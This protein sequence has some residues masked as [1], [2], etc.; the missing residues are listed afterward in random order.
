[1]SCT[2]ATTA[3]GACRGAAEVRGSGLIESAVIGLSSF[4][5]RDRRPGGWEGMV[6]R[7]GQSRLSDSARAVARGNSPLLL[8]VV[9]G[10]AR[11]VGS[12]G[13]LVRRVAALRRNARIVAPVGLPAG[14]DV[15]Q[16]TS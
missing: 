6:T 16:L 13:R 12:A 11:R 7:A 15:G 8:L 5:G 10:R 4:M 2:I 1:M 9:L 3:A 14:R